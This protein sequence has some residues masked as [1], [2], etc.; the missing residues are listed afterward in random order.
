M[1]DQTILYVEDNAHNR[2]IVR[3]ILERRGYQVI[4]AEDGLSGYEMIRDLKPPLVLLDI[5]L[6]YLDGIQ[7]AKRVKA[8]EQLRHIPLIALTA[9]AMRGDRERFL[10]AG[11]DDYLSKPLRAAELIS[12]V[13]AYFEDKGKMHKTEK[14]EE[15]LVVESLNDLEQT[16]ESSSSEPSEISNNSNDAH[17][18][19]EVIENEFSFLQAAKQLDNIFSFEALPAPEPDLTALKTLSETLD[20]ERSMNT[21]SEILLIDENPKDTRLIRRMLQAQLGVEVLI[22]PTLK[23]GLAVLATC[24]PQL[25]V[26]GVNERVA[27]EAINKLLMEKP[28][29]P[30]LLLLSR[31]E[32]I[33]TYKS[34]EPNCLVI[35]AKENLHPMA[36]VQN[37]HIFLLNKNLHRNAV[38][39]QV[40][41]IPEAKVE[42]QGN[43][44]STV[45]IIEDIP[46]SATL[47]RKILVKHNLNVLIAENGVTGMQMALD[48]KPDLILL[49][50]GLPDMD[51]QTLVGLL[52]AESELKGTSIIACTAWPKDTA[53]RMV[54]TYGFDDY[55]SKPYQVTPFIEVVKKNLASSPGK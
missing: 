15:D 26:I 23:E 45:L 3:K 55:I 38:S 11:C 46:D 36:I 10:E 49:D 24:S 30:A 27:T 43:T 19:T 53:R 22:A 37:V 16:V 32:D 17:Q 34:L 31:E 14:H 13:D 2:R 28:E 6:P 33:P 39:S 7:I 50:L 20:L 51:G 18:N 54:E 48:Q 25:M 42:E 21:S 47:A 52:R 8:N 5:A 12:M 29:I 4:E 44:M 9:S 41:S 35:G 40:F 1:N